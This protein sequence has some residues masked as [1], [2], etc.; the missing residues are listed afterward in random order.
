MQVAETVE[1]VREAVRSARAADRSIGFVPTMGALHAGHRSLMDASRRECDFHI[2]SIFVNP[3]QFG[4]HEDLARYPRPRDADLELCRAAGIDLVFYPPVEVMYPPNYRTFVEVAGLSSLLEGAVRPGHFR[5]VATVVTKLL[6]IAG[7]DRAYFGQKDYQQQTIIRVMTSELN[8]PT[9]IRVCPTLR[10]SDGMA[11]S[12]RNA[13]LTP[14]QRQAGRSLSR[15]LHLAQ[16]IVDS[17]ERSVAT[18]ERAMH[19]ILA[20]TPGVEPDYAV[21]RH[22]DTLEELTEILPAMVALIAARVGTTRLI[23]NQ[24]LQVGL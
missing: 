4:P 15:A 23:D 16:R 12:S 14:E 1:Q 6:L 2:V 9:E 8:L 24:V 18:I 22:P 19:E 21:L 13:Y 11:M 3:T 17:G 10:D 5:G 7:A 20:G